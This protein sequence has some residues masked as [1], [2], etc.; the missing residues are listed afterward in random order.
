MFSLPQTPS[1]HQDQLLTA[2]HQIHT[3]QKVKSV[4]PEERRDHVS[5]ALDGSFPDPTSTIESLD[6]RGD[7]IVVF[8][9]VDNNKKHIMS[10]RQ[11]LQPVDL[12]TT[13]RT[14]PPL[15]SMR[16]IKPEPGMDEM[17]MSGNPSRTTQS[18]RNGF[19]SPGESPLES[20]L[21]GQY[22]PIRNTYTYFFSFNQ[23]QHPDQ[24][25]LLKIDHL[26]L[27]H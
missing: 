16:P 13:G 19:A 10:S 23:H 15:S 5:L 12:Q 1:P 3:V 17:S 22:F 20:P 18:G 27:A 25:F 8:W 6:S 4:Y 11:P 2:N 9:A 24:L 26:F 14:L 7:K 21:L